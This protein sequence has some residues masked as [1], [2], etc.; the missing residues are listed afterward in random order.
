MNRRKAAWSPYLL[1]AILFVS[2]CDG[3][4]AQ[5]VDSR[6][7]P[8]LTL[9]DSTTGYHRGLLYGRVILNGGVTHEG[10]LRF[11]GDEEA[12][13]GNFFNGAKGRN[14]WARFVPSGQ[15]P[16]DTWGLSIFGRRIFSVKEDA[17][18]GRPF[19]MR[20]GDIAHIEAE[21]RNLDVTLKSGT[22]VHL[23]RYGADDFADGVRVWR[24]DT[25]GV[26]DIDE[27]DIRRIEFLAG[28]DSGVAPLPLHGTVRTARGVF[29]GLIQW[30]R[31]QCLASDFLFGVTQ[32]SARALR[33]EEIR[34]ITRRSRDSAAVLLRDGRE[35]ALTG[36]ITTTLGGKRAVPPVSRG[37]YVDDPRYGRV[38][39]SWDAF[40]SVEL[41]EGG[42]GP[43]YRDF[44]AGQPLAGTVT[45]RSGR[46]L[47]GRMVYDLDESETTETLDA[48][49]DG[50]N[51][52]LPFAL[53]ASITLPAQ[54]EE[55]AQRA[56]VTLRSGEELPL[57]TSGDLHSTNGG[58]LIFVDG[59]ENAEYVR[60]GDVSKI[61]FEK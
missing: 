19:M 60:W 21:G 34:S 25:N 31:E 42:T 56:S 4:P 35:V 43:A 49:L 41:S 16:T 58:L 22:V 27:W 9:T 14:P 45:T 59:K 38:L 39:I 40:E 5:R 46:V 54:R 3:N 61:E 28:P 53:I 2:A 52:S 26:V 24:G 1:G 23:N 50:V 17:N 8:A 55:S 32:E 36:H 18:L 37:I 13:W 30:N 10:R 7:K 47:A 57:P 12:L 11:G 6:A 33:F 51:Y 44:N 15:L 29:T 48:E 20:F